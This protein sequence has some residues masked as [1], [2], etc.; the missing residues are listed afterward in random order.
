MCFMYSS[1]E[2]G[3]SLKRSHLLTATMTV[4]VRRERWSS[5]TRFRVLDDVGGDHLVLSRYTVDGVDKK[6]GNVTSLDGR[7]S[8]HGDELLDAFLS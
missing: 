7:E 4:C 2:E 1:R 6:D 5:R 3:T 8:L